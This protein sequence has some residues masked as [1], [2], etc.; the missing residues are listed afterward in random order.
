MTEQLFL[1]FEIVLM[2]YLVVGSYLATWGPAGKV[3]AEE[4]ERARGS[5]L[6]NA[7]MERQPP[8]EG[9]LFLF[10][11]VIT[12]VFVLLWPVFIV[13]MLNAQRMAKKESM[14]FENKPSQGQFFQYLGGCGSITCI[15]C[16]HN[17]SITSFTHGRQSSTA[18]FQCQS[19][20]CFAAI[21]S[22]GPGETRNYKSSLICECG[23]RFE[24]E[25]VLFC[26]E[27][28]SK[29][30]SYDLEFIT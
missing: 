2:A 8:S 23:G 4:I 29:N 5:S 21:Q 6:L 15:D 13:G 30:L 26:P 14:A 24:R 3:I 20:G 22:G 12:T 25:K 27:C 10:R 18:G 11:I 19:C 17:E 1:N 28:R 16:K 9:K 7:Y